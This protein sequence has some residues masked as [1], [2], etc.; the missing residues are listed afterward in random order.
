[1][2]ISNHEIALLIP[3]EATHIRSAQFMSEKESFVY[4]F[5]DKGYRI[6]DGIHLPP[7]LPPSV[8]DRYAGGIVIQT[9]F[10]RKSPRIDTEISSYKGS[11]IA[12]H[13]Q[14][15]T[16]FNGMI[17]CETI[18]EK[19]LASWRLPDILDL[20]L[21]Y[22]R[23]QELNCLLIQHQATLLQDQ[24]YWCHDNSVIDLGVAFSMATGSPEI[25]SKKEKKQ[26]RAI[27]N[28]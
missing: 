27:L 5:P 25:L 10:D 3:D 2:S 15:L 12:L 11:V 6:A 20:A 21:L 17:Y 1:M 23:Q 7:L 28:Y 14:T 24:T 16:Y 8:G 19:S 22:N 18:S 4:Y 9:G 13:E 26:I